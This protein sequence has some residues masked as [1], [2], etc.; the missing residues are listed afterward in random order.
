[1]ASGE[2]ETECR[3]GVRIQNADFRFIKEMVRVNG[4][5]FRTY[6]LDNLT[7][8]HNRIAGYLNSLPE[9]LYFPNGSG[10]RS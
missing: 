10:W 3:K 6:E 8:L 1:M 5:K 7:T 2:E 4:K 9:Y